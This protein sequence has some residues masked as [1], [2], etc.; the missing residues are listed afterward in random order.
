[1]ALHLGDNSDLEAAVI[2]TTILRKHCTDSA[3]ESTG[4]PCH[5]HWY[6]VHDHGRLLPL[7]GTRSQWANSPTDTR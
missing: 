2:L 6:M 4:M 3:R 5:A 7:I 1:M